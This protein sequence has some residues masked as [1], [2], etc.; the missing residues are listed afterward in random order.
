MFVSVKERTPIIGIQKSLGARNY[1]ILLQFLVESV[2][3]CLIG[4]CLGLL[5]VYGL[6]QAATSALE[7][8]LTLTTGNVFSGMIISAIIGI[9]S[10]FVPALQ[11]SR[12]NPVDAIRSV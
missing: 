10:G 11:A 1:F 8:D 9:I 6:S 2:V 3:L 12:M 4:G 7:F 5:M